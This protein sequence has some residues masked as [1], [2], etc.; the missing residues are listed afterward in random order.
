MQSPQCGTHIWTMKAI[1]YGIHSVMHMQK[2]LL[3]RLAHLAAFISKLC[4]ELEELPVI[5][6]Q[7]SPHGRTLHIWKMACTFPHT[8]PMVSPIFL[9]LWLGGG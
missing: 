8:L 9:P 3:L 2:D 6:Y 1:N 7:P 5:M 4:K